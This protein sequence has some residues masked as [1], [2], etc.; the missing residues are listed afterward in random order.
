MKTHKHWLLPAL[1]LVLA[2]SGCGG[3]LVKVKGRLTYQGHPVPNTLVTFQPDDPAQRPSHGLTD[4]KGNFTLHYSSSEMG[5]VRG[6]HTVF[7]RYHRT[8]EE[9]MGHVKSPASND[10][11]EVIARYADPKSSSLHYE[12]TGSGQ[13]IEIELK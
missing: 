7:L 6:Q 1:V 12:V 11:K 10:L 5:I 3:P 4:G 8:A 13:L 9:E 2:V